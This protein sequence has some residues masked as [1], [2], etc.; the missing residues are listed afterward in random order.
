MT[1]YVQG[2]WKIKFRIDGRMWLYKV[3]CF[4]VACY[5]LCFGVNDFLH[6]SRNN[7]IMS[8]LACCKF[9]IYAWFSPY[10]IEERLCVINIMLIHFSVFK[11]NLH[12][13]SIRI[14]VIFS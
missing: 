3:H 7:N 5:I 12:Y 11:T 13:M 2:A 6:N 9:L 4:A 1:N 14:Y 10:E 8:A